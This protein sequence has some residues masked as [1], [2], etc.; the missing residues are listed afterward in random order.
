MILLFDLAVLAV[1]LLVSTVA[2]RQLVRI[3]WKKPR[4][5]A[6][7]VLVTTAIFFLPLGDEIVGGIQ[8]FYACATRDRVNIDLAA[9][10]T[11]KVTQARSEDKPVRWIAVPVHVYRVSYVDTQTGREVVGFDWLRAHGGFMARSTSVFQSMPILFRGS[12]KPMSYAELDALLAR[13]KLTSTD[14]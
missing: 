5:T 8:F 12:C 3:Y 9:A 13:L 2:A 4:R 10:V 1:W 11:R 14:S 6:A 7:Q